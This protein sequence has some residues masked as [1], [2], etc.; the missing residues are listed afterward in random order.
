[1]FDTEQIYFFYLI[2][3]YKKSLTG[4]PIREHKRMFSLYFSSQLSIQ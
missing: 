1:M 3:G 4:K 2:V